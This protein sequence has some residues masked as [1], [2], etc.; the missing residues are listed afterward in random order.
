MKNIEVKL[1]GNKLILEIDLSQEQGLSK[2]GNSVT[3][4]SSEGNISVP[5][6]EDTKMGINVYRPRPK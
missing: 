3:I 6:R 2:S 1:E 5:G 4:A